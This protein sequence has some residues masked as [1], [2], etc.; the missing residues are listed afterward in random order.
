MTTDVIPTGI[1]T[2]RAGV[3]GAGF[4]ARVH[5]D[6]TRAVGGEIIAISAR[7]PSSSAQAAA[8]IGA[9]RAAAS[10]EDLIG[11][12]DIDVVHVCTPN[13]THAAF[14][15]AA[16]EAGKH[17]VCEKPLALSA[18]DAERL[19][20]LAADSGRI[21]A[22]PFVYRYHPMVREARARV[23]NGALGTLLTLDCA[24]L[25]DWMLLPTDDDWRTE[26]AQG[27]PSRAFADIGSHLCDLVEFVIGER[28]VAVS[29]RTRT[30][31]GERDGHVVDNEDIAALL[32]ETA[33]GALG[34]VLISQMAAGRRNAL[35]VELHGTR[36]SIR[37]EQERPEELW[38]GNRGES[39]LVLR[40]PAT[41]SPDSARL[42]RVPAGHPMGYLDAFTSF[43]ADVHAAIAGGAPEGLPTFADGHRSA[44]LT[45]AVLAS[46]ADGGRS[47]EVGA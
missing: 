29:A 21:A 8:R 19:V 7:T 17:V 6:A 26:A 41:S 28:I 23:R 46:A 30:V 13:T 24:Y 35:T 4:M 18:R 37:F 12:A 43:M 42:Q 10:A 14:A 2:I 36:E 38:I 5:S 20:A 11:A 33:S 25:Q 15:A 16:L 27:G 45:E 39:R 44:V 34:T 1:G 40:D 3:L 32:V 31:F 9:E 22:V 47:V